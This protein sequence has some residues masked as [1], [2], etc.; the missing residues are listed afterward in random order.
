MSLGSLD[1]QR[2]NEALALAEGSFGL[3][4]PNPRVGCV[5]G[6]PDGQVLGRGATQQ[7]D[8]SIHVTGSTH[9]PGTIT[10]FSQNSGLM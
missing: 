3:T 2:M 10:K 6:R 5:I 9:S 1:T 8:L 7:A 4:E